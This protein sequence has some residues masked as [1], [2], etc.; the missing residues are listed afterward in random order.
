MIPADHKLTSHDV[1]LNLRKTRDK[2]MGW[3]GKDSFFNGILGSESI[4]MIC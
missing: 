4:F 3:H 1:H 2:G